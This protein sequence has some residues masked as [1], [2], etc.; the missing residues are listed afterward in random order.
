VAACTADT[1]SARITSGPILSF[2][3]RCFGQNARKRSQSVMR[4]DRVC[5]CVPFDLALSGRASSRSRR[6]L[7]ASLL[8]WTT[9]LRL[10]F[11]LCSSEGALRSLASRCSSFKVVQ[12]RLLSTFPASSSPSVLS[13]S[14]GT[15]MYL[16]ELAPLFGFASTR[17]EA[18]SP[19]LP[20]LVSSRP[21]L[22]YLLRRAHAD[23]QVWRRHT[24]VTARLYPAGSQYRNRQ[25]LVE[26]S[27]VSPLMKIEPRH[28]SCPSVVS[29]A[30]MT[31]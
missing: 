29:L 12:P 6:N 22:C 8:G 23:E 14:P 13:E 24:I 2:N 25:V 18:N 16:E 20:S 9:S 7:G 19:V 11:I 31:V 10:L 26:T 17:L 1:T 28:P 4:A 30:W 3:P 21:H 15:P 27:S 5:D